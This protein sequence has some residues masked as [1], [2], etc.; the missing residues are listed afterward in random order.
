MVRMAIR[1]A[2]IKDSGLDDSAGAPWPDIERKLGAN[3][4]G[5]ML[6]TPPFV[7]QW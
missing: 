6:T 5:V 1:G 7:E 3:R 2:K 4:T